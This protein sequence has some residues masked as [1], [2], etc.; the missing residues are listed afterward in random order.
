[1]RVRQTTN[2]TRERLPHVGDLEVQRPSEGIRGMPGNISS[3]ISRWEV[4][5]ETAS[6]YL[7]IYINIFHLHT[8]TN[9]SN[10]PNKSL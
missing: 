8:W 10:S 4:N 5:E 1:M 2:R 9:R 7:A 6:R 3:G